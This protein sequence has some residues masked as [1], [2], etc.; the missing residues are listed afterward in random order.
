M[1]RLSTWILVAAVVALGLAATV[2]ALQRGDDGARPDALTEE[3][4]APAEADAWKPAARDALREESISG[5]LVW[6][7]ERCRV[8]ALDLSTLAASDV[9][10][11]CRVSGS[12]GGEEQSS[13]DGRLATTCRGGRGRVHRLLP[14]GPQVVGE[15]PGC[16]PAWRPNGTLTFVHRGELARHGRCGARGCVRTVVSRADLAG[17][18]GGPPWS[19]RR[20]RLVEVAWM[21]EGT[22]AGTV[23]DPDRGQDLLAVFRGRTVVGGPSFAYGELRRLHASPYGRL[24]AATADESHVIIV[25]EEGNLQPNGLTAAHA[26]TWSPDETWTAMAVNDAV[27]I[28]ETGTRAIRLIRLPIA[29]VDLS[30]R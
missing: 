29:A 11:G 13:R 30:W 8:R 14:S 17:A 12:G 2:D 10:R 20:P 4:P 22:F 23:R 28:F 18:F 5:V 16:S 21:T 19:I 27:Y 7:D 15:F 3:A 26:V 9:G 6:A 1:G 25:D 24:A